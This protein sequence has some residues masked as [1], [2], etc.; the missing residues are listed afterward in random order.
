MDEISAASVKQSEMVSM[1]ETG[2][3]EISAVVQGNSIAAEKS[4]AVSKE[5]SRQAQTLNNLIS[6]FRILK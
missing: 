2:I 4:A 5:L 6:R 1:I 3:Q